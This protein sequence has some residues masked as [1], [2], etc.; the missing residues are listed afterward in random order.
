[1]ASNQNMLV[2]CRSCGNKVPVS[3]MR[4]AQNGKD[5]LC[6]PCVEKQNLRSGAMGSKAAFSTKKPMAPIT[7]SKPAPVAK[8]APKAENKKLTDMVNYHCLKCRYKFAR[9]ADFPIN[10]CPYCS[11]EKIE[12]TDKY[13]AETLV[14]QA[15]PDDD[16]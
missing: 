1:M 15:R 2:A 16:F 11:S 4:L 13:S 10:K 8:P 12:T 7:P 3:D 14:K 9:K 5:M 6:R